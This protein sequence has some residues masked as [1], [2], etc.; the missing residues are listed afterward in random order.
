MSLDVRQWRGTAAEEPDPAAETR[1]RSESR[2]LLGSLLR[3]YRG[4]LGFAVALLLAQNIAGMTGPYLVKLGIDRGIPPLARPSGD[5][6]ILILVGLA[7]AVGYIVG[8][9]LL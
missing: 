3:P 5:P 1:M 2:R 4:A 7:F 6:T 9:L 8:Q